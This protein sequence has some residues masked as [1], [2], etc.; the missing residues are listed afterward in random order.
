VKP[1]VNLRDSSG[2]SNVCP[3]R[4]PFQRVGVE[5]AILIGFR[6]AL[7]SLEKLGGFM[8]MK[9]NFAGVV[10][11]F[12][13][14]LVAVLT[15]L[16]ARAGQC[17]AASTAGRWAYTYTGSIF[18]PSGPVPAASVG[19][20][21]QDLSGNI[22]GSQSRSVAGAAGSE[23]IVGS[24]RIHGDSTAEA[25]IKVLVDGQL[26]RTAVLSLVF[27]S[28]QNHVRMIFQ[29]LILPDGTNLPVVLTVDGARLNP[30]NKD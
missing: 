6:Y 5:R 23:D 30:K 9:R 4:L 15:P 22:A 3:G 21:Y 13:G 24:V 25:T 7:T 27:D 18:T 20:Y 16:Q 12:A 2:L 14:L 1:P 11:V 19:H 10:P 26:Q 29:S 8:F 17:S 28:S